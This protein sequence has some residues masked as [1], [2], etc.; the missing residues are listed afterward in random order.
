MIKPE[1]FEEKLIWYYLIGT[2][3]FYI[4]GA[5]YISGATIAWI[6]TLYLGKKLWNQ[7]ENTPDEEKIIIPSAIWVWIISVLLMEF[8]LIVG[9]I[10]FALGM[11]KIVT[12]SINLARSWVLLALFPLIGCLSIR[13]QLLY[14][15]VCIV[16]LQSLLFIPI[17]YLA[18]VFHL[19][20]ILY[21]SPLKVIGGGS[22]QYYSVRFYYFSAE[23]NQSRLALFAPWPPALGLI[24]NI[25][26]FLVCQEVNK[27]WRWIGMMGSIAMIVASISRLAILC[28]PSVALL[29]WIL[30]NFTRPIVQITAG[31]VSVLT[32]MVAPL[33]IEFIQ[34]SKE[35]FSKVRASSSQVR[36]VLNRIALERW[37]NEAPLWGHGIIDPRG[38][39]ITV[40][41]PIGTH[42]TWFSILFE[43]GLI[44]LIALAVPMLWS[45]IDLL[46]KAYNSTTAKVGLNIILV[47]F[48]FTFGEKV[49]GLAY[50][51]WPGLVMMGIAFKAEALA[52]VSLENNPEPTSD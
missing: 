3:G 45:F 50:L 48:F 8:I 36:E 25:Y 46:S 51:Y 14:R 2:Y 47:I 7:T 4:L 49:E 6:L 35:R 15:G 31:L 39:A 41:V 13:S 40:F 29:T 18:S 17:C 42:H 12:S 21:T 9:H 43:K 52:L 37:W 19:S 26:F 33:L 38:P 10:D 1:N 44:G 28:I 20:D 5:Q 22:I 32:G 23:D 11:G 24:A 30:V 27:K 34:D 16:C